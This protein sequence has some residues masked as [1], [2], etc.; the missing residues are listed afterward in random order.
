MISS[1]SFIAALPMYD[2][3]EMRA[4]TDAE[5][6]RLREAFRTAGLDA[7][8]RLVRRNADMPS[9][10][11]GIRDAEGNVV[12]PDPAT[13]PPDELHLPTLWLHP[14]LLFTQTCWGPMEQGLASH[15][16]VV[17]QPDYSAFPGGRGEFY[18]SALMMRTDGQADV[19]PPDDGAPRLPLETIRGKRL[20]YNSD[21]SMS[22][23]IALTR[24]LE[25]AGEGLDL[26]SE[27]VETGGH[28]LSI[29]AVAE[30]QADVCAVDCRTLALAR[31]FEP[32]VAKLRIVGWTGLRKGLPFIVPA[33]TSDAT[34]EKLQ[35][36]LQASA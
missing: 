5:W 2:W 32:A 11:G 24:D 26:F 19:A 33:S 22:G 10:P 9:V 29:V 31:R 16:R 34:F 1:R 21:D 36:A 15:V 17:S 14:S 23:I 35:S 13:L 27:L 28:R 12:A 3:P 6:E 18:S 7:P 25:A 4:E 20:A 30:G 8:E